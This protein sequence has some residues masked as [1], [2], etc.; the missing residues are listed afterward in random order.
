MKALKK[1]IKF[2][3]EDII[4]ILFI[5]VISISFTT[6]WWIGLSVIVEIQTISLV[7]INAFFYCI[8]L[9]ISM[10][11]IMNKYDDKFKP[12]DYIGISNQQFTFSDTQNSHKNH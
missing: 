6:Y 1:Q 11:F 3:K 2:Q 12:K 10:L 9:F 4:D 8:I 5:I 7:W